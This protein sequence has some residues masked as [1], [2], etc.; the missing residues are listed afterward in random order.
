MKRP[1]NCSRICGRPQSDLQPPFACFVYTY[2][3]GHSVRV[4]DNPFCISHKINSKRI[5]SFLHANR[6]RSKYISGWRGIKKTY[7][8]SSLKLRLVECM[9]EFIIIY[10]CEKYLLVFFF[11]KC[12]Y[13]YIPVESNLLT[14]NEN[15]IEL[16]QGTIFFIR[17][18]ICE[19]PLVN[20]TYWFKF[21]V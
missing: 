5:A 2:F 7:I 12:K 3:F 13:D 16:L 11:I 8:Q 9:Y 4:W 21:T 6:A 17:L 15:Q 1:A 18:N 10:L 14:L 20:I 19:R